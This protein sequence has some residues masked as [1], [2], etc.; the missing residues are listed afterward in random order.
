MLTLQKAK[1]SMPSCDKLAAKGT[2]DHMARGRDCPLPKTPLRWK[3]WA[4]VWEKSDSS[5]WHWTCSVRKQR[6]SPGLS[7]STVHKQFKRCYIANKNKI[8]LYNKVLPH[9]HRVCSASRKCIQKVFLFKMHAERNL[10]KW[11]ELQLP[12]WMLAIVSVCRSQ[13]GLTPKWYFFSIS[14]KETKV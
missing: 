1:P 7:G 8:A 10:L 2:Q 14:P 13:S 4:A 12:I 5:L 11:T 6:G 9:K 3:L